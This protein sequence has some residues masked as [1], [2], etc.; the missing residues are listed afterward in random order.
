MSKV[1]HISL[2]LSLIPAASALMREPRKEKNAPRAVP[3]AQEPS[4]ISTVRENLNWKLEN[5]PSIPS[6]KKY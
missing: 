6:K 1:R 3:Q 4:G 2:N 5:L